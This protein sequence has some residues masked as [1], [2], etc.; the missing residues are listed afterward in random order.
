MEVKYL[1]AIYI[2][3][4]IA[5]LFIIFSFVSFRRKKKYKDGV[6]AFEADYLKEI[7]YFRRKVFMYRFLKV[8]LTIVIIISLLLSGFL[9][10]RPF[11]TDVKEI[12]NMNRDIILCMDIST[13]VDNL[14]A[15]LVDKL[16]DV[17][18][19]LNGERFGIVIF[20]TS[21][22]YLVPLTTDYEMVINELELIKEALQM[23]TDYYAGRI[24]YS[25]RLVELDAYISDGTLVGNELRGSSIIG[26]GLAAASLDF[27]NIEEDPDRSRIIIFSTDNDLQGTQIFTLSEASQMCIDRGI[28]VYGIGTEEMYS[29]DKAEMKSAVE[30]T[31]GEFYFG[32][33]PRTV[34]NI[35]QNIQNHVASLDTIEHEITQT[36]VPQIPF[37]VLL[38]SL[39][40]MILLQWLCKV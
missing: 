37:I 3:A 19:S 15:V 12:R 7:P 33:N 39:A 28:T 10:A 2:S 22:V 26:D 25:S 35:I 18:L 27:S 21:P 17:V 34:E 31:G 8:I 14:N 29:N 1:L 4:A 23:R 36:D 40:C 11:K 32:E 38:I 20:N 24:G 16:E 13:T 5:L 9:A 30:A 6:K